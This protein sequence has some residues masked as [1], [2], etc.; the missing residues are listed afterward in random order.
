MWNKD[1]SRQLEAWQA[2]VTQGDKGRATA[3]TRNIAINDLRTHLEN[4]KQ[5]LSH[6]KAEILKLNALPDGFNRDEYA[7]AYLRAERMGL[8][9]IN[10]R[11][12]GIAWLPMQLDP[13]A[14][15]MADNRTSMKRWLTSAIHSKPDSED[16]GNDF[17]H[18]LART[19]L[20]HGWDGAPTITLMARIA[21]IFRDLSC[22][23]GIIYYCTWLMENRIEDVPVSNPDDLNHTAEEIAA[24]MQSPELYRRLRALEQDDEREAATKK[25]SSKTGGKPAARGARKSR[26]ELRV[27]TNDAF[28]DT[29]IPEPAPV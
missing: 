5:R 17:M 3:M 13:K 4:A 19:G 22:L 9:A 20:A 29:F 12:S 15:L 16:F 18:A 28:I 6:E 8:R 21:N 11:L 7:F 26:P 27:I 10:R 14:E 23:V 25:R 1:Q 2:R 24:M